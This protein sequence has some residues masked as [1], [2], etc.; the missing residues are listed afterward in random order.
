MDGQPQIIGIHK[1]TLQSIIELKLGMALRAFHLTDL[2]FQ[3][4]RTEGAFDVTFGFGS[5][6]HSELS[7]SQS[8]AS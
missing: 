5:G 7:A 3:D 2:W 6:G 1:D 4:T 8:M